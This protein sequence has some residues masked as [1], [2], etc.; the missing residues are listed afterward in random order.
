MDSIIFNILNIC[1]IILPIYKFLLKVG[2]GIWF[3][4]ICLILD[5]LIFFSVGLKV[6]SSNFAGETSDKGRDI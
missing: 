3:F 5:L 1:F 4:I 6:L 2:G